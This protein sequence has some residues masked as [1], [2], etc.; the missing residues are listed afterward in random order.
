MLT[1]AS[2]T[3]LA[4]THEFKDDVDHEIAGTGYTANG[5]ALT[6]IALSYDATSHELRYDAAD[7]VWDPSTITNARY[8]VF[9]ERDSGSDATRRLL[10]YWN[11]DV[12]RSSVADEFRLGF[13][14][15]GLVV[16]RRP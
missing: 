5:Q 10:W 16:W 6:S 7:V 12:N 2:Y 11:L 8:A 9:Y 13:A 4:D 14:S 1:D 15:T 3:P